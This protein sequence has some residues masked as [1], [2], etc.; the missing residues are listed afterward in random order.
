MPGYRAH[1]GFAGFWYCVLL[2]MLYQLYVPSIALI[3]E[4]ALCTLFGSLCP[5]IDIKSK[6]QKYIYTFCF[7][8]AIPLL[9]KHY[10][11]IV[12]IMGW[13]LCIPIMV[14]HRGV[15]HDPFI[16]NIVIAILWLIWYSHFP[17]TAKYFMLH[18][19]CFSIGMHSHIML[20]YG[21]VNYCKKLN[22]I[23]KRSVFRH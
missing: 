7:L 20:D 8:A 2:C 18:V 23:R 16:L 19:I 17:S 4:L 11:T 3:F 22:K 14:K 9:C 12:A 15:F 13:L 5:D 21:I 1:L 6:G 10:F